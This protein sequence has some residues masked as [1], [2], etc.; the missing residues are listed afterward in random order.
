MQV[1]KVIAHI[2]HLP[3]VCLGLIQLFADIVRRGVTEESV[4]RIDTA[5]Q[6]IQ[7]HY[8]TQCRTVFVYRL[9][10]FL[11]AVHGIVGV[12][13]GCIRCVPSSGLNDL[14]HKLHS[15]RY[16]L[17]IYFIFVKNQMQ[18]VPKELFCGIVSCNHVLLPLGYDNKIIHK[19]QESSVE[20]CDEVYHKFIEE[21]Q[22][23]VGKELARDVSDRHTYHIVSIEQTLVLW[24][25]IP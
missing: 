21:R 23:E 20:L 25:I 19:A 6:P 4:E 12:A 3:D 16:L 22:V 24:Q 11:Q 17:Q 13:Y 5:L 7:P 10:G 2:A 18:F 1:C 8:P 14:S 15:V 9:T